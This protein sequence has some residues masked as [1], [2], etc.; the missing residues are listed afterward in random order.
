M[1][2][3]STT[4]I[5]LVRAAGRCAICYTDLLK[6]NFTHKSLYRGE[7]AHIVGKTSDARSPRGE[8]ELPQH[9]RDDVE[10]LILLCR[11]CHG[12]VDA[13]PNLPEF[14]VERLRGFKHQ[15]ESWIE[16]VLS[17]PPDRE[18]AILRLHGT[19]GDSHVHV[20]RPV[21]AAAVLGQGRVARFPLN[22]D[23]AGVEIDLR[24]IPSPRLGDRE[25][26][27]TSKTRIDAV[28]DQQVTPAVEAGN[29]RHVSVFALARW[30]LLVYLG[31]KLGD[32]LDAH[33]YQ[34][35]RSTE[36]WAW[37]DSADS[38]EFRWRLASRGQSGSDAV[39]VLS[40]SAPVHAAEV[41]SHLA[42]SPVY[43]IA[44]AGNVTPH[45]DIID[46]TASLK[47]A[48]RA[49]RDVLADIEQNR[50]STDRLH[51][52][53]AAPLS[54]CVTLGRSVTLGI[55]PRLVLYDRVNGQYQPAMEMN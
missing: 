30:P 44:P 25:Y 26:Y 39:L 54:A 50:K 45:Y 46:S 21:A 6:S 51:V 16:Q 33:I 23:P 13:K 24:Q 10:N 40:L 42:G 34:R 14:S 53:G 36:S 7:R 55:H 1:I 9:Q 2:K 5:L 12:E 47:S 20:N 31:A 18:T 27:Q 22:H 41:P 11:S 29:L 28:F 19:I 48:E 4:R 35:H 32:K 37:P 17:V 8:H 38:S 49:M 43:R 15:H 3:E 52:M